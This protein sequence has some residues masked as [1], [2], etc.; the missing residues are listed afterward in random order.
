MPKK[1]KGFDLSIGGGGALMGP[2]PSKARKAVGVK[3]AKGAVK[4]K[5]LKLPKLKGV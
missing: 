3:K 1:P 5:G 4:L 2:K